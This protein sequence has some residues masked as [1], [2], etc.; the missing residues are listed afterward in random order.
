MDTGLYGG[1]FSGAVFLKALLGV[2]TDV[3]KGWSSK[4]QRCTGFAEYLPD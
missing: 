1:Q 2:R 4:A 3:P